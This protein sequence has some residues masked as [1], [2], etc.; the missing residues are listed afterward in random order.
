MVLSISVP[1]ERMGML[2][3]GA[4]ISGCQVLPVCDEAFGR[5][6]NDKAHIQPGM[7]EVADSGAG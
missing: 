5:N 7:K 3:D 2:V 1:S 4:G 6:P